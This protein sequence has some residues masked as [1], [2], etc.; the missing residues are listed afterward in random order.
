MIN[1]ILNEI[2][3][4]PQVEKL[5]SGKLET[6][7]FME[8]AEELYHKIFDGDSPAEDAGMGLEEDDEK[9]LL[10]R[11]ETSIIEVNYIN[12]FLHTMKLGNQPNLYDMKIDVFDDN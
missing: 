10:F 5:I 6:P 3:F 4:E 7:G 2:G 11:E 1:K 9:G 12:A 8:K